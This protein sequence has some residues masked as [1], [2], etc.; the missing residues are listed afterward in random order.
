MNL[1]FGSCTKRHVYSV[2]LEFVQ[3]DSHRGIISI[4]HLIVIH[5]KLFEMHTTQSSW[6]EMHFCT[7]M[8]MFLYMNEQFRW[9]YVNGEWVGGYP[10]GGKSESPP[11][12]AIYVHP[13]S[14]N[15]GSH[16]TG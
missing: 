11:S 13:E 1:I 8:T 3:I 10:E 2:M 7:S 12:Q 5:M 4:T 14:P 15:F 6:V 9:R 16:C